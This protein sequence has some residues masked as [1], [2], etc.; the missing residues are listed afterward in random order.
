[1]AG[2]FFLR[3]LRGQ[4]VGLAPAQLRNSSSSSPY[5]WRDHDVD[6]A[7]TT[8][9]AKHSW[10]IDYAICERRDAI[11][12][13]DAFLRACLKEFRRRIRRPHAHP[14]S[15]LPFKPRPSS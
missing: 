11:K 5:R 7:V 14:A 4:P 6:A 2:R 15:V 10:G 8:L 1:L 9:M 3:R 12:R 13:E